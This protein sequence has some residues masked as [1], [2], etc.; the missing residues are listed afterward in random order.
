MGNVS[1]T[2]GLDVEEVTREQIDEA[3]EIA[4]FRPA[5]IARRIVDALELVAVVVSPGS[6][7]AREADVELLVVV[8][9]P[10]EIEAAL[11]DV[12]DPG[13]VASDARRELD[14]RVRATAGGD[15]D[16]VGTEAV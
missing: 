14:R 1:D 10:R 15:E 11:P 4:P 16:V 7:R 12:H 6:V 5:D 13:A 2:S 9:V 8:G 3:R